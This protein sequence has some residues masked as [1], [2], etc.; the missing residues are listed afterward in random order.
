MAVTINLK[1]L[2]REELFLEGTLTPQELEIDNV[3]ELVHVTKPVSYDLEV[4]EAENGI[5]VVGKLA[6]TLQLECSRC[7]KPFDKD[8][9]LDDWT[10]FLP[11]DGEDKVVVNNDCIDLTP[12]IREDILLCFPQ[13]PLCRADCGGLPVKKSGKPRKANGPDGS[14]TSAWSELNKLKF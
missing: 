9:D 14:K 10:C 12:Y 1:L 3:D 7:L 8:L 6:V 13:R 4:Q 2:A 11:L 5:L